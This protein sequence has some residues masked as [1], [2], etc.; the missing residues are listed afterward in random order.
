MP[1]HSLID[2]KGV[3]KALPKFKMMMNP[4]S[5]RMAHAVYDLNEVEKIEPYHNQPDTLMDKIAFNAIRVVRGSYDLMTRYN[6][7]T[8]KEREWLNRILFLETVAGVPGMIGGMVRH[9]KS[10]R[11][12]ENDHGWIH[13]LL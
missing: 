8:M 5:Y 7:E 11:S 10:L 12:L 1:A 6:P 4:K 3:L 2:K 9:L 13:H